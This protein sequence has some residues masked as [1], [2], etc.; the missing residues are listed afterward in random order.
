MSKPIYVYTPKGEAQG[1]LLG[2]PDRKA[3]TIA[4]GGYQPVEGQI[5]AA[6]REKGYIE[7][8]ET[9]LTMFPDGTVAPTP[10]EYFAKLKES[11]PTYESRRSV[12]DFYASMDERGHDPENDLTAERNHRALIS[13]KLGHMLSGLT[14]ESPDTDALIDS[15]PTMGSYR[16]ETHCDAHG[17][18]DYAFFRC[19][20]YGEQ[21]WV[22]TQKECPHALKI[23]GT[24]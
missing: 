8:S 17:C 7:D 4:M 6:W 2:F 16:L 15:I 19:D 12:S 14:D 1:K 11:Q 10:E 18:H 20:C 5:A 9:H 23:G 13:L 21:E 22:C 24:V 3:G